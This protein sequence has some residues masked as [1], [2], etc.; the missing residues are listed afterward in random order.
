MKIRRHQLTDHEEGRDEHD[1]YSRHVEQHGEPEARRDGEH[2]AE[3]A[4]ERHQR[5]AVHP[6]G[7]AARQRAEHADDEQQRADQL[8][9]CIFRYF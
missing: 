4:A 2:C 1:I 9:G 7:G 6:V 5:L 3:Q 8:L